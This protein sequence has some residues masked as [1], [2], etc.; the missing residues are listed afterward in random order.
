MPL[1]VEPLLTCGRHW[2][3]R[4][5]VKPSR[6][7]KSHMRGQCVKTPSSAAQ[8]LFYSTT[9]S[10]SAPHTGNST[11]DELL[12]VEHERCSIF[13]NGDQQLPQPISVDAAC[14]DGRAAEE[15][16]GSYILIFHSLA[17]LKFILLSTPFVAYILPNTQVILSDYST[18][19]A[20]QYS[21]LHIFGVCGSY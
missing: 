2:A 20:T 6:S 17:F 7:P 8:F 18:S 21:F 12:R 4:N 11:E 15:S 16:Q 1:G 3:T 10:L 14:R 13:A 9:Y 19:Y 5:T